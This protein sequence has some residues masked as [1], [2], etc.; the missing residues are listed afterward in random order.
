MSAF[1][2]Q[3]R[4]LRR[5]VSAEGSGLDYSEQRQVRYLERRSFQGSLRNFTLAFARKLGLLRLMASLS[6]FLPKH[7]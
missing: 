7:D 2:N 4:L 5:Q 3:I 6:R 1:V